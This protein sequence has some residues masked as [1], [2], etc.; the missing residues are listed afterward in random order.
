MGE[1]T[2]ASEIDQLKAQIAVLETEQLRAQEK[3]KRL[4]AEHSQSEQRLRE[5]IDTMSEGFA[6]FDAD[7]RLQ[8]FNKRYAEDVWSTCPEEVQV[9]RSFDELVDAAMQ[10]G[11][12]DGAEL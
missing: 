12:W 1:E 10:S 5:A 3:I 2:K 4:E 9:G 6:L 11:M 7:D 8:I